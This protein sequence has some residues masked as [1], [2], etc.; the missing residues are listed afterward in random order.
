MLTRSQLIV[1]ELLN[2]HFVKLEHSSLL[3]STD[4]NYGFNTR[5]KYK[6]IAIIILSLIITNA[7]I[8]ISKVSLTNVKKPLLNH[9]LEIS[10]QQT[11]SF[12]DNILS[13][14]LFLCSSVNSTLKCIFML[15]PLVV[16]VDLLR[17][18]HPGGW[19]PDERKF[20]PNSSCSEA[21]RIPG[22]RKKHSDISKQGL[23]GSFINEITHSLTPCL[24][25]FYT[26]CSSHIPLMLSHL[27]S[28]KSD[29]IK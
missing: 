8:F 18:R 3:Q 10:K 19:P 22:K 13:L 29:V 16:G 7:Y 28:V 17:L 23:T 9:R 1:K 11:S 26:Y 6:F 12:F 21:T 15:F 20:W 5:K 14:W 2:E 24:S 25:L 4:T 27:K